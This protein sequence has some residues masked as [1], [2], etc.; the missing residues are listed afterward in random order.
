MKWG[1]TYLQRQAARAAKRKD[2]AKFAWRPLKLRT[3]KT[4][5]LEYVRAT[6]VTCGWHGYWAFEELTGWNR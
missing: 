2:Y 1:K 5:W 4:V 6:W 3:G